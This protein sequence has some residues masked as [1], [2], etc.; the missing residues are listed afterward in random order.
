[1][2]KVIDYWRG[3]VADVREAE[4]NSADD[5]REVG[6][7]WYPVLKMRVLSAVHDSA[8]RKLGPCDLPAEHAEQVARRVWSDLVAA[9]HKRAVPEAWVEY[10][11][12]I[13][14]LKPWLA[15]RFGMDPEAALRDLSRRPAAEVDNIAED[16]FAALFPNPLPSREEHV[17]R[18]AILAYLFKNRPWPDLG[19][20]A[21]FTLYSI[22]ARYF[23]QGHYLGPKLCSSES[24]ILDLVEFA[25]YGP[26]WARRVV[27][28]RAQSRTV[29]SYTAVLNAIL[30]REPL[31][32][33]SGVVSRRLTLVEWL[34]D[35][36]A[37]L[38]R[39]AEFQGRFVTE[40]VVWRAFR[41]EERSVMLQILRAATGEAPYPEALPETQ[42][43]A[44]LERLVEAMEALALRTELVVTVTERNGKRGT[45]WAR[46]VVEARA[47]KA[48]KSLQLSVLS[49]IAARKDVAV[50]VGPARR[51]R[52]LRSLY[53]TLET[54]AAPGAGVSFAQPRE[55]MS[56]AAD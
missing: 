18:G 45:E 24:E 56:P 16:A 43:R 6:D 20:W 8:E 42:R 53:R 25:P 41:G 13:R 19:T 48:M 49:A 7:L 44:A 39:M 55:A 31:P 33:D 29:E 38:A 50:S 54:A 23:E 10:A 51:N 15:Q 11:G 2:P 3:L 37:R 28:K 4:S 52:T 12:V 9:I 1:M 17:A 35:P 47:P 46:A 36:E 40:G 22:T 14:D 30:N 26:A 21:P 32:Q 34:A 5:L 27:R